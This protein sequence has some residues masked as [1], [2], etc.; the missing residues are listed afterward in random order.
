MVHDI[1][2]ATRPT[3]KRAASFQNSARSKGAG[4]RVAPP[5]AEVFGVNSQDRAWIDRQCVDL[6]LRSLEQK[7]PLT[8]AGRKVP[9][10]IYVYATGW[11]P[12][13]FT[14]FYERVR[15]DPAWQ[16]ATVPCGHAVMVDMPQELTQI[17]I[18]AGQ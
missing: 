13:A 5:P 6:P 3:D 4:F 17:L 7:L 18:D 16:T 8:G 9:K 2:S 10:R 15:H 1:T 14:Q 11:S 12:S